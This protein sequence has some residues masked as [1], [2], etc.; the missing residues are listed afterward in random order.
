MSFDPTRYVVSDGQAAIRKN[1]IYDCA[2]HGVLVGQDGTAEVCHNEI[3]N[4][5]GMGVRVLRDDTE[6]NP[7]VIKDSILICIAREV[8][9]T[10]RF[11]YFF[12]AK[13]HY[14]L[15]IKR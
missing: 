12:A 4:V 10:M 1:K 6:S 8:G 5:R 3:R 11:I 14:Y 2:N 7:L 13:N 15:D 9:L